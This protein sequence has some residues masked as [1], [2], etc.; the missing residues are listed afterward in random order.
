MVARRRRNPLK[1]LLSRG[2]VSRIVAVALGLWL[3]WVLLAGDTSLVQLWKLKSENSD[4]RNQIAD[5]EARLEQL[6][7]DTA[8]LED[9]EYVEKIAREKYGM[10]RDGE[11]SYRVVPVAEN[12]TSEDK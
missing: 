9:P 10:I 5:K 1:G 11:T 12:E 4:V 7:T 6:E 3:L 8:N 2:Q